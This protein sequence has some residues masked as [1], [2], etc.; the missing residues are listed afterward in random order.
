M[1]HHHYH[2]KLPPYQKK[3]SH[4]S[5][6]GGK[7]QPKLGSRM[8]S[9]QQYPT[10]P[11]GIEPLEN[12]VAGHTFQEGTDA[13]GLLSSVDDGSI[14]KPA[15]KILCGAREIKFYEQIQAATNETDLVLLK[16]IIPLYR[17]HMKLP[18]DGKLVEFIKLS[19][20][21]HGMLEPCIMD[22]KIG[23]RTWDP[24]ATPEKRRAEESKYQACKQ[25]LGLCIPGF[26]VYSLASGR[27]LRFGKEYGKKLN[28]TTVKD[29]FRKFL[30]TDSGLC[31]QLLIQLL[32]DL[33][34][35][36]KWARTQ[37]TFRLYSSSV[38][39]VYDARRLKPVLQYQAK[40][41]S[42]SSSKLAGS[43]SASASSPTG[44]IASGASSPVAGS[45]SPVTPTPTGGD[46]TVEPLQHY[47][48][49]QRSHSAINNYEED[50]KAMRES[51][52]FMRDNL[53][54][55]YENKVW[56]SARMID[57]AHA[58]PAEESTID[59]NYLQGIESLI[60]LDAR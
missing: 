46:G 24:L 45:G 54:G 14:L 38:L 43:G 30:N 35:I 1:S 44:T 10:L 36:Q 53:V 56:A 55:S 50:M 7:N 48:K 2:L 28:E 31:R 25:P 9:V 33:W 49:I 4:A 23:C 11:E 60:L 57:F 6:I 29:A 26:Q 27:R 22:V 20:L 3:K 41:L 8:S 34:P 39:L 18:V 52:V 5:V 13:I 37:T 58:F 17:G 32:S 15:G 40:S 12:Q 21:T 19:D 47:Y 59:T 42:S 16:E 51:Y